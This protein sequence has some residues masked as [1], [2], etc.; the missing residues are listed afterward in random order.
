MGQ[1][2]H[3]NLGNGALLSAAEKAFDSSARRQ[4]IL[5][6]IREVPDVPRRQPVLKTLS[7]MFATTPRNHPNWTRFAS[8]LWAVKSGRE[9]ELSEC[10]H[11][12]IARLVAVALDK[13]DAHEAKD[14][15]AL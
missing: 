7:G 12:H 1:I 3:F 6:S 11:S 9:T 13:Q 8:L 2:Y 14:H 5:K 4:S 15:D 10:A